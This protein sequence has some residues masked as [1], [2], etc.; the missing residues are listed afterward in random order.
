M[1]EYSVMDIGYHNKNNTNQIEY[2]INE[3][4][5]TVVCRMTNCKYDVLKIFRKMGIL[6]INN[7]DY[8]FSL[9]NF[10]MN[11]SYIGKAKCAE[12]DTWDVEIGKK[13]ARKRMLQKY[14]NARRKLLHKAG[15]CILNIYE[16]LKSR[17]NYCWERIVSLEN[18]IEKY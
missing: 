14:Y 17:K 15:I 8:K 10:Y 9:D 5:R 3:E 16:E 2:Y 4:K 18:T 6:Y 7:S 11:D 13:I 1:D 12:S